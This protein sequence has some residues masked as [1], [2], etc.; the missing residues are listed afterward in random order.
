M[1]LLCPILCQTAHLWI[2]LTRLS[3]LSVSY[4]KFSID[5]GALLVQRRLPP[6]R[7]TYVAA[8]RQLESI[9]DVVMKVVMLCSFR[10]FS[11]MYFW[12]CRGAASQPPSFM[13]GNLISRRTE[14]FRVSDSIKLREGE[15]VGEHRPNQQHPLSW[16]LC[17]IWEINML[18]QEANISLFI[19]CSK[20]TEAQTI[21]QVSL[22][23]GHSMAQFDLRYS[24]LFV[25]S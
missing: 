1:L 13:T 9:A 15:F 22:R 6:V 23:R 24:F 8:D 21:P 4:Q 5:N 12:R 20:E 2:N 17:N 25:F 16:V 11:K 19:R 14:V 10:V 3:E 7:Q 18:M